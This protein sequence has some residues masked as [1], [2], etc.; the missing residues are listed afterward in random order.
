MVGGGDYCLLLL[1]MMLLIVLVVFVVVVIFIYI[2]GQEYIYI[3]IELLRSHFG[4][5]LASLF[6]VF[7][8]VKAKILGQK[9]HPAQISSA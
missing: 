8:F 3:Y 7:V 2:G 1:L 5:G 4:A 9:G 6:C